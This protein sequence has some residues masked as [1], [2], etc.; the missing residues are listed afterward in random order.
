[1]HTFLFSVHEPSSMDDSDYR[2]DDDDDDDDD[3]EDHKE[4]TDDDCLSHKAKGDFTIEGDRKIYFVLC[5]LCYLFLK[6]YFFFMGS[7]M[8]LCGLAILH[9]V[10]H[11]LINYFSY[12]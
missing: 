11:K 5:Y 9:I 4:K 8:Y 3:E 1:M 12:S 10:C 6:L 2:H 7:L